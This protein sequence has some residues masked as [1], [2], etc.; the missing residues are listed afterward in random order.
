MNHILYIII[1][2][3]TDM[4]SFFNQSICVVLILHKQLTVIDTFEFYKNIVKFL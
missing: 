1:C 3:L 2:I 4:R